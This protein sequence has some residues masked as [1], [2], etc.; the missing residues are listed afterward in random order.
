MYD[1]YY[2]F[3]YE[4]EWLK[5]QKQSKVKCLTC[6][7]CDRYSCHWNTGKKEKNILPQPNCNYLDIFCDAIIM[8]LYDVA[9]DDVKKAAVLT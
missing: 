1:I 3:S 5:K 7:S 2:D 6:P 8:S 4:L 9:I